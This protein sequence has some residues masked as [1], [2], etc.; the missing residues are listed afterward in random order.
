MSAA[1]ATACYHAGSRSKHALPNGIV[2]TKCMVCGKQ[3]PDSQWAPET[4][5]LA[6]NHNQ[7]EKFLI[8]R[9]VNPPFHQLWQYCEGGSAGVV[10]RHFK[11]IVITGTFRERPDARELLA[12]S[13]A[14]LEIGGKIAYDDLPV[15]WYQSKWDNNGDP[16]LRDE[17]GKLRCNWC[18]KKV[19]ET[20][21]GGFCSDCGHAA[22]EAKMATKKYG[23]GSPQWKM[24]PLNPSM[25][26][27]QVELV[28]AINK[29]IRKEGDIWKL[30]KGNSPMW[31]E[32]WG[33]QGSAKAPYIISSKPKE[34]AN[35]S[36]TSDGWACSC[37]SFT[38]NTPRTPCK[39]ILNVMLKEGVTIGGKPVLKTASLT[40]ADEKA[41]LEWKRQQAALKSD[42]KPTAGAKLNLFGATTRKFR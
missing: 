15:G 32:Q 25:T 29:T 5:I 20:Y 26:K 19:H 8:N 21:K 35:G 30:A 31:T 28:S 11:R 41:F 34:Q 10:G 13:R 3:W 4:L 16:I 18:R 9:G 1:P 12:I 42:N 7:Y 36:T 17:D 23:P 27:A 39:H 24:L 14:A 37:M 33:Y 22:T 6:G 40:D 2:V 38:R